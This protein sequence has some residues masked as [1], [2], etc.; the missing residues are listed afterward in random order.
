MEELM[1]GIG[2]SSAEAVPPCAVC[3]DRG[4]GF[5]YGVY[6]CEGCKGFFKRTVQKNMMYV[7]KESGVCQ[8]NKIT[9]NSCQACRLKRCLS[10]G[11]KKE[12]VRE[13][14]TPGGKSRVKKLKLDCDLEELDDAD[15]RLIEQ[16][17]SAAP[18]VIPQQD[19]SKFR[20]LSA[21][22]MTVN[23]LMEFGYTE[24]R[25]VIEWARKVPGF[26]GLRLEDQM[27]LLKSSYMELC[28][29][30]IAYRSIEC[31]GGLK[32][33]AD[34]VVNAK[35]CCQYGWDIE[36]MESTLEFVSRLAQTHIDR[37]EF[38]ILN[39]ILLTY[40]DAVGLSDRQAV[41][42]LQ[43]ELLELLQRYCVCHYRESLA[44]SGHILLR[45]SALRT[46]AAKSAEKYLC[47]SL[48]S[49]V[50]LH[51]LVLEMMN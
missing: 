46:I 44:R 43:S 48:E 12:A 51:A 14:H 21:D 2:E 34:H 5:H 35:D 18:D 32:F 47:L 22:N 37:T 42:T 6:S 33:H 25:L 26:A 7:C 36:L 19:E 3:C 30:R 17:I 50:K 41:I 23:G 13:D 49:D 11:M 45:L 24:L 8:I 31:P 10:V 9:R 15:Q 20:S 40:P 39:A 1:Q 27:A 28:I 29:L 16:L 4:S 38:C